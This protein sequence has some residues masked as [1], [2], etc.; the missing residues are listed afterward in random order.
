MTGSAPTLDD[1]A[2]RAGV[3]R[4]TVSN[5]YN[6][7]D[8]VAE[9]TMT[10]VRAAAS[11]LGFS[12][13]N[14][15]GR[16]LRRGRTGVLGLVTAYPLS[17]LF[18]D[19]G[20]ASWMH[21]LTAQAA[22]RD[23]SIQV[24]HAS[25]PAARQKI[26]DSVV[27]GWIVFGVAEDDPAMAAVIE[28]RQ[29]FVACPGPV[30]AG[31]HCVC[32]DVAGGVRAAID[33]LVA[34]GHEQIAV[35]T[36]PVH[37]P[38]WS[39]RLAA[40]RD[41]MDSHGRD[42]TSVVVVESEENSRRAGAAVAAGLLAGAHPTAVFAATDALALGV[43]DAASAIGLHVPQDLSVIGFDDI[44]DAATASPPLTTVRQDLHGQGRLA[45]L[46]LTN[47]VDGQGVLHVQPTDLIIRASTAAPGGRA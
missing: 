5:V 38:T 11:E 2:T 36:P 25:G 41:A 35:I 42:W 14:P 23:L 45:A 17:Y 21:G 31:A 18:T 12:G 32:A 28:R 1:V 22:E 8:L 47:E 44:D 19:P 30:L 46:L 37:G 7:P 43:M 34:L 3:S 26:A 10:K 13:P 16:A 39:T 15:A 20:A 6:H 27:D 29:P 40:C 24:I 9:P 33:H 4:M